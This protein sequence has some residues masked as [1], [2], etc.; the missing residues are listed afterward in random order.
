QLIILFIIY[1]WG[2]GVNN[3]RATLALILLL[4][5]FARHIH[6]HSPN[7][8]KLKIEYSRNALEHSKILLDD[9]NVLNQ[10]SGSEL[11]FLLMPKRH[12]E[13][14]NEDEMRQ[15]LSFAKEKVKKIEEELSILHRFIG[16]TEKRM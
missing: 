12:V 6:R 5:Q 8:D 13:N 2:L 10:F 15:V 1:R 14:E 4:D 9:P 11:T 3:P 7:F 16:A